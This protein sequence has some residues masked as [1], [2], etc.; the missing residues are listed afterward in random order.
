MLLV[1]AARNNQE[2]RSR[3]GCRTRR[4]SCQ[5]SVVR[6]A[7][8]LQPNQR[9]VVDT[10]ESKEEQQRERPE[11]PT[12]SAKLTNYL[13][14]RWQRA[15]NLQVFTLHSTPSR[16]L[17]LLVQRIGWEGS[18]GARDG[19]FHREVLAETNGRRRRWQKNRVNSVSPGNRWFLGKKREN[20][21]ATNGGK[22]KKYTDRTFC[23]FPRSTKPP[24]SYK[25]NDFNWM[26]VIVR[27]TSLRR[28]GFSSGS[29]K[30][31]HCPPVLRQ[32]IYLCLPTR[33]FV[34]VKN[35]TASGEETLDCPR[36]DKS[37]QRG[38]S[39][40][41]SLI[42]YSISYGRDI[43]NLWRNKDRKIL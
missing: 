19:G 11:L 18:E 5:H 20:K 43:R 4:Q 29:F 1:A 37:E 10:H 3:P 42:S 35:S 9:L 23:S 6:R 34:D 7:T 22:E 2:F 27:Q 33:C 32:Q 12:R 26:T 36:G 8:V 39:R 25:R 41:N 13:A 14:I 24:L 16:S 21:P 17:T 40:L 30:F 38:K 15:P 28:R 31:I